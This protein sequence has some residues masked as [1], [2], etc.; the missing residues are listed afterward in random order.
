MSPAAD[1]CATALSVALQTGHVTAADW[2]PLRVT[3]GDQDVKRKQAAGGGAATL[4]GLEIHRRE[5]PVM[6]TVTGDV[7]RGCRAVLEVLHECWWT[8]DV[9]RDSCRF[10][11]VERCA[12]S[13]PV[14]DT[15]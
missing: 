13:W 14:P 10:A 6:A 9:R 8:I 1:W 5:P 3:C 7:S 15:R 2:C 12:G 11:I 4:S